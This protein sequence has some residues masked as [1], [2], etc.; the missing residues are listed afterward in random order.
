LS[1]NYLSVK[2]PSAAVAQGD[3]LQVKISASCSGDLIAEA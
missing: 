3:C 2:L 1:G